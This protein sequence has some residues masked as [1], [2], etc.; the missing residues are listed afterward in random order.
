MY[1]C[2]QMYPH[3]HKRVYVDICVYIYIY[4]TYTNTHT[5]VRVSASKPYASALY[6]HIMYEYFC[7]LFVLSRTYEEQVIVLTGHES[8]EETG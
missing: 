3:A 2:S 8:D 5:H 4:I 7:M 6:E 1:I